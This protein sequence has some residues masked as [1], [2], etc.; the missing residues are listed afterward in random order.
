[1]GGEKLKLIGYGGIVV[2]V[3]AIIYFIASI[4]IT[5]QS[6]SQK[7]QEEFSNFVISADVN[8]FATSLDTYEKSQSYF[9]KIK[10]TV[11]SNTYIE[12]VFISVDESPIFA[13]PISSTAISMS[14]TSAP[15]LSSSSAMLKT[16]SMTLPDT[17]GR[18]IVLQATIYTLR[19]LDVFYSARNSFL[20]IFAYTLIL[21]VFI[22][23]TSLSSKDTT[24]LTMQPSSYSAHAVN[25]NTVSYTQPS[26][27]DT[28][29][30][31]ETIPVVFKDHDKT[32][33]DFFVAKENDY[34][35][36]TALDDELEN[37][38]GLIDFE[39]DMSRSTEIAFQAYM[40]E[41]ST[42]DSKID[43][44]EP[45]IKKED[46]DSTVPSVI[47]PMGLF[48]DSTGVSWYSYMETRLDSELIRAANSEQ[49]LALLILRL[50]DIENH[51]HVFKKVATLLL[52]FFKFRDFVF[53][54]K[55]DGFACIMLDID[56]DQT[57]IL[58]ETLYNHLAL[59]LKEENLSLKVGIG[60]STRSL[61]LLPGSRLITEA[62]EAVEKA[63]GEPELPIVAFRV[64]PDKYR[65]FVSNQ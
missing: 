59:L 49:D 28:N 2:F 47:D 54:Y 22:I 50:K 64:S 40:D 16:F 44:V 26:L 18:T 12:A 45:E 46:V 61:R 19:P 9:Q 34:E 38:S 14:S 23:F 7:A 41:Y 8:S 1:M 21:I 52:D 43:Y 35:K 62:N 42:E 58:A 17:I 36:Y 20:I 37:D 4:Y 31:D 6:G 11:N 30:D 56:L 53:E 48:S 13:Y 27:N 10:N 24:V 32:W 33:D 39:H 57:M 51:K 65:Q 63:F 29:D 60:L 5:M 25:D 3:C 15:T 55:N